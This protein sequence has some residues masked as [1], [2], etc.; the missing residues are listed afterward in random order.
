MDTPS[1]LS[2]DDPADQRDVILRDDQADYPTILDEAK[3]CRKKHVRL[4]LIDSGRFSSS[5]LEW[6]GNA[7]AFIATSDRARKDLRELILISD[8]V[9]KGNALASYFHSGPLEDEEKERAV[10]FP[11][12]KLMAGSGCYIYVSNSRFARELPRLEELAFACL[13]SES[14]LAYYH[15]GPIE[16]ELEDLCRQGAWIHLGAESLEGA[17]AVRLVSECA[18]AAQAA[19]SN[20]ILHVGG[21]IDLLYL[22]EV[23]EVGAHVLFHT[24]PS[25]Y[26]SRQRPYELRA[27]QKRLDFRAYYL[28][29][30][31]MI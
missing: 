3:A 7:G 4:R 1:D 29:P 21:P 2:A 5:E 28:F 11:S 23:S 24:P 20:I 17:D 22:E 15:H 14:R 10:S 9:K 13:K 27:G 25:D 19:G 26:R 8:A 31:L 18:R 16:P 6:L 30:H 12:L